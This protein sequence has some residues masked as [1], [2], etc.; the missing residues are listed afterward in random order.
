[1]ILQS[2]IGLDL[3][4]Y[5]AYT[6]SHLTNPPLPITTLPSQ[7]PTSE[8]QLDL[9]DWFFLFTIVSSYHPLYNTENDLSTCPYAFDTP[10]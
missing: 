10:E 1:M 8:L 9:T 5:T 6:L 2:E 7:S 3:T 4:F